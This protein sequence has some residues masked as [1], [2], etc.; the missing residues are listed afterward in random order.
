MLL[1]D[2]PPILHGALRRHRVIPR[3]AI[4]ARYRRPL[5]TGAMRLPLTH[6][7]CLTCGK[8]WQVDP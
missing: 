7:E 8:R 1:L 6:H 4:D 2:I 5:W 3:D